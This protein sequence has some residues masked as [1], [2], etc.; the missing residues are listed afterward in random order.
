MSPKGSSALTKSAGPQAGK[1]VVSLTRAGLRGQGGVGG[2]WGLR[3]DW[4]ALGPELL[5][6]RLLGSEMGRGR[7]GRNAGVAF[8]RARC[9]WGEG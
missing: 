7:G 4:R 5:Q 6:A 9:R 2:N 8:P 3:G 1:K